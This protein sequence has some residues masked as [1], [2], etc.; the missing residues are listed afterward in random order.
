MRK[1]LEARA[2][3][4]HRF[5]HDAPFAPFLDGNLFADVWAASETVLA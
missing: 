4:V 2:A 1:I 3:A 5:D